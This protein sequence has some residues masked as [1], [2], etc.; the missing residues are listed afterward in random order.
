ML[1]VIINTFQMLFLVVLLAGL[2]GIGAVVGIAKAYVET[3]PVL[4]IAKISDQDQTSFFY[5]RDG[6][7][8]T[9]YKGTENRIM[10]GIDTMPHYLRNAFVA[11][12]DV[13]FYGHSGVD[14]KRIIGAF[15]TNFISGSQQGGSTITQQ[16]IK[17]TLLSFEQSY[18]RKIQ[19]AY[20]ALQ[21]ETRYTK[22]EILESYLNTIYLG[23]N[24]YG[25]KV[26]A[27]GYF[28]KELQELTLRECAMLAGMTTNPYYYNC[29][30]NFF[31]RQ[32]EGTDYAAITNNR[33]NYV[34]RVMY[35]HQMIT[36]AEFTEAQGVDTA[37]VLKDDPQGESLYPYAHYV[38]YAVRDVVQT[39]L[40]LEGLENTSANRGKME[41]KLRT[42]GYKVYL[43]LDTQMQ[44]T[45]EDTL[46][47]YR[48]YPALRDPGTEIYRAKNPDG[49]FADIIQ[50]QAGAA[51]I[52]YRTGEI[53]AIVGSRT[54][55]DARKTLNRAVDMNMPVGSSIKPLT[56]YAPAFDMGAGGG[57]VAYNMPLP[58]SGWLGSDRRDS[59]PENYGGSSY[60]GPESFRTAL[61]KS[62][63]TAAAWVMMNYVGVDRAADY[64]RRLGAAEEHIAATPF[65][66]ALG[67]SGLTPLEM[68]TA[69]GVLGNGGVYQQPISF[70]GI[71]DK[72]GKVLY[73]AHAGQDRR[74]V[75]KPS[76]AW[77]TVD[78]LKQVI[79]DGTG[80]SA[81]ING[82]TVAGKT[83]TNSE[84]KGVFFSGLTGW[85]SG[86]VWIGHDNYKALSSKT[87][88]GNSAARLWQIFMERIHQ[89]KN[90]QNRDI[91]DGGPE[92]YG[93]VRVTTCAVSGQL[94]TEACRHD[95]MGYGTVTDYVAREAAPQVSCQMHQNITTCTASNMIAGPYC[96]PETRATRG[97]L[98]LPQ[99]H[100]LARFANTQYANVLSQYLGPYAAAGSGL[101]TA[102][103]C[104]LH[105]HGGDYGQGIVTNTLLPDAQVLL[106]QASA[107]LAA[108]PPGTPQYDGLLG[109]INNLN[110]VISQNPGLDTLAGAMGILTQ[111]MAA[112]MP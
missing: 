110:S 104:T 22:D 31:T 63:N 43:A 14:L 28:G 42:G 78:I 33:T 107:Q 25:V 76:T 15:A 20:L 2:A 10:V 26:A 54:P 85:Y 13:R 46:Y 65:G 44:K 12:E 87:T 91:L 83:G 30:R 34:L 36:H 59:W 112:A 18:K 24:Y 81:R 79:T 93:L 62:D 41:T 6:N 101:A 102:Q 45:L 37:T 39:L 53:K 69:F 77:L 98:V 92:S 5:D 86:A 23:E 16:L 70:L 17:N 58:I 19:E 7:L 29:R 1:A 89:D 88:G 73:D 3:A 60:R 40:K 109:A 95:A 9:D 99:G 52:D 90:L 4:D 97:V 66:V 8:I 75:Y 47:N 57:S 49:T 38:E 100:P 51:I 94:A 32:A 67:A 111:A 84:Q 96:P 48:D 56:V 82:Q 55:P 35:E 71:M 74:Q 50:P 72:H 21:L 64:L 11:A 80:R 106:I 108:L 27:E 103:T 68:A 61:V 105:T